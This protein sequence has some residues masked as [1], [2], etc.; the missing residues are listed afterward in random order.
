[1]QFCFFIYQLILKYF[2]IAILVLIILFFS[3]THS[4][5]IFREKINTLQNYIANLSKNENTEKISQFENLSKIVEEVYDYKK[6]IKMIIG[7]SNWNNLEKQEKI[8]LAMTFRDFIVYN[9]ISR[10]GET[11][12]ISFELVGAK[13]VGK[14]YQIVMTNILIKNEKVKINYLFHKVE[15]DWKV[16]DVLLDGAISEIATKKTEYNKLIKENGA[17]MLSKS[18][19]EK[20]STK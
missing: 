4:T 7:K 2:N 13:K 18:L 3:C 1:M 8:E 17:N 9:Y 12:N 10:F 14:S 6:M 5:E 11:D 15:N 19:Q 16:F 20:M